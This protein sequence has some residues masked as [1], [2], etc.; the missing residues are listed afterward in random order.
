MQVNE[1]FLLGNE[2]IL[3]VIT[4]GSPSGQ[5]RDRFGSGIFY[6]FR[7]PNDVACTIRGKKEREK[8]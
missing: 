1:Q 4:V 5:S 7:I 2:S 6:H 8:V 3:A